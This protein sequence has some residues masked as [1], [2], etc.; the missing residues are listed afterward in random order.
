M[1]KPAI[2]VDK[3]LKVHMQTIKNIVEPDNIVIIQLN[4]Q[5]LHL[6][7]VKI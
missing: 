1:Q 4:M 6:A 3:R 7:Y 2:F 5:A